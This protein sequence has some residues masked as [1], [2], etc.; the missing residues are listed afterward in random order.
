MIANP[1]WPKLM[2]NP[3]T[4][5]SDTINKETWTIILHYS[6]RSLNN[7]NNG[8][9]GT[10]WGIWKCL[11]RHLIRVLKAIM[12]S[13][14]K[15]FS[16]PTIQPLLSDSILQ[17]DQYADPAHMGSSV[18]LIQA[19]ITVT[20]AMCLQFMNKLECCGGNDTC[21]THSFGS[22]SRN[23]SFLWIGNGFEIDQPSP[24]RDEITS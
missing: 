9:A 8:P 19:S 3:V 20:K 12:R 21:Q 11:T 14:L 10:N 5:L 4:R 22:T 16:Q 6:N 2:L 23:S 7:K 18:G 24:D 13:N 1:E 15:M 17:Q